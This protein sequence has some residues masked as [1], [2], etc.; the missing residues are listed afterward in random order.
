MDATRS[1]PLWRELM[2]AVLL[3]AGG[4]VLTCISLSVPGEVGRIVPVWLPNA[5]AL[6]WLLRTP[7]RRWPLLLVGAAAGSLL[8]D[9]AM[10]DRLA[11][12]AAL[13]LANVLESFACAALLRWRTD[14]SEIDLTKSGTLIRFIAVCGL[15][16]PMASAVLASSL[17]NL[18]RGD[19][20]AA[21]LAMWVMA[22]A[23]GLL[24]LTPCFLAFSR[25]RVLLEEHPP[26][27][28]GMLS[29]AML[30]LA[31]TFAFSLARQP[32]LFLLPP[33]LLWVALELEVLGAVFGA[34]MM[35]AVA[36]VFTT[37]R[38]SPLEM[39]PGGMVEH[40][41][42]LQ[43]FLAFCVLVALP[44]ASIRAQ[45]RRMAAAM[46][47]AL[48]DAQE[49]ARRARLAEQVAGVGY[50]RMETSSQEITWSDEMYRMFAI[51][52]DSGPDLQTAMSR[53]H[54]DDR[55]DSDSMLARA[56]A[57][58]EGW[59]GSV[60]RLVLPDGEVR[61]ISGNAGCERDER[62][63]VTAVFGALTDV[64]EAKRAELALIQSETRYRT[65]A[66][67]ASDTILH[68]TFE[69]GMLYVSPA[70][71]KLTGYQPE[72]LLVRRWGDLVHPED[73][74]AL[75]SRGARARRQAA[76]YQPKWIEYRLVRKDGSVVW[77]EARPAFVFDPN[78][79][80]PNGIIDVV[81]D[82]S[83]RK[84]LELELTRALAEAEAA[85]AVKTEF[86]ANMSHELRT[87]ITA[88]VGFS[89]LL[90]EEPDL[91][92][93]ARRYCE[94]VLSA[95]KALLS[96]V[97]DIL[98][99]SRLEAGQVEIKRRA[100]APAA[101][102][103]EIA[104]LF[105]PEAS[106][107]GLALSFE[108]GEALPARLLIDVDRLRQMLLNLVSNAIKFTDEGAVRLTADYDQTAAR[109]SFSVADTGP[110]VPQDR[111]EDLFKRFSQVDG[112][113]TRRHGGAGLGLA[114]CKGLA[115]AM[116]GEIGVESRDGEGS[117]FWF[118]IPA[119]VAAAETPAEEGGPAS[120][121]PPGCRILVVD[122]NLANRDLARCLLEPLGAEVQEAG[123]GEAAVDL[124]NRTPF[125]VILMDV[126]MP[127]MNGVDAMRGIRRG[128]GPNQSTP[129]LAFS[130]DVGS[131]PGVDF[132]EKGF[133]GQIGKP[134]TALD[135]ITAV[136]ACL[137]PQPLEPAVGTR[138]AG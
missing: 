60:C 37:Q 12:A 38:Q 59:D 8:A 72:E 58:G 83:E 130:A 25:I 30:L 2:E 62:G 110:G 100:E 47:A 33:A 26:T 32:M 54:P 93:E 131:A 18:L 23:L 135:L 39:A 55:G 69:G 103:R 105:T 122:D 48:K 13:T 134:L 70:G 10:G 108:G 67:N 71:A 78:T 16:G 80:K 97:N 89:K 96:Q 52:P 6:T 49:Q 119:E 43:A 24:V 86:L 57:T 20:A 15:L 111:L 112:S 75:C 120:V 84:L 17:L 138:R 1:N 132:L 104:D 56:L 114:I 7:G 74:K 129:I 27:P 107:K 65:L 66:E 106:A 94:R 118:E 91:R 95:S 14:D 44:M 126:R 128:R 127:R 51:P 36:V 88:V 117:R 22:D 45:R 133:D 42:M 113:T 102:A 124:A 34:L 9:L 28:R 40:A 123:D 31:T 63:R 81:R 64:T 115:D 90:Q 116:G 35:G 68:A 99:F 19:S 82:I 61:H 121:F 3:A 29:L 11:V 136:C 87:P 101:L 85:A 46:K 50:W 109:L 137:A 77:V 79:G 92:P 41:L 98:D 4:F 21:T 73:F 125:D 5:L 53:V 76:S